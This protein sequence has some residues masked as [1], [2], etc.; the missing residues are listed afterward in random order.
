MTNNNNNNN[1][2]QV[3]C[4]TAILSNDW[5]AGLALHHPALHHPA[6]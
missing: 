1:D 3:P 5:L 2:P 6:Q 4:K